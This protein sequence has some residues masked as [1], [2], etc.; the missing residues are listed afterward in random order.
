M[1]LSRLASSGIRRG[2]WEQNIYK[3]KFKINLI[4]TIDWFA[5][6]LPSVTILDALIKKI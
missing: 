5:D 4:H 2:K 1:F 6:I 3:M